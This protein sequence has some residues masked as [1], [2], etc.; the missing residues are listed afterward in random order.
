MDDCRSY[1]PAACPTRLRHRPPRLLAL[2]MCGLCGL[3]LATLSGCGPVVMLQK[4]LFGD[5]V[6]TAAFRHT[7]GVD[8]ADGKQSVLVVATTPS[9][10]R[11]DFP[12]VDLE[13]VD[14]VSRRLNTR[15]TKMHPSKDVLNWLDDRG[16]RWDDASEIAEAFDV[17][18]IIHVDIDRFS[19][20][21]E[22]SVD[23]LRG[24]AVGNVR[25]YEVKK[26][27]GK[28][29]AFAVFSREINITYPTLHPK[30]KHQISERIFQEEFLGR[31][32][33]QVSQL[34][35]DHRPSETVF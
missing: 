29:A 33:E 15:G 14:R 34:F 13:I 17:D 3:S 23:L 12:G 8:L 19:H 32:C 28:R 9:V 20:L 18:Y 4:M 35:Y 11:H 7:T 25:A 22:N 6:L 16:G 26:I 30:Q 21:E 31:V 27:A 24:N 2:L 1:L 5:P 10:V